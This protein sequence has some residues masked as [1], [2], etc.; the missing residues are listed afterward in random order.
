MP[1]GE[2]VG[3]HGQ[4]VRDQRCT[5]TRIVLI[6]CKRCTCAGRANFDDE[7]NAV[8]VNSLVTGMRLHAVINAD[9]NNADRCKRFAC[10]G[11]AHCR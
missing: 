10:A 4:A 9:Q 5:S 11:R 7:I 3:D 2:A 1:S 6:S 8:V